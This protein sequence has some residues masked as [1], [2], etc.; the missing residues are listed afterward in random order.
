MTISI[1]KSR[2]GQIVSRNV[3][4]VAPETALQEAITLMASSR[5]SCLVVAE[6]KRPIGIFTERDLVKAIARHTELGS[7]PIRELMTCPVVTIHGKLNLYEAYSIMLSNK[8]RHHVVVDTVG[9]IMGVMS[10]SDLINVLGL[11]YFVEMRLIEQIMTKNV[12]TIPLQLKLSEALTRMAGA[13]ISCVV[14]VDGDCPVG[15]LTERDAVRLVAEGIDPESTLTGQVMSRPVLTVPFGTTLHKAALLMKQ[16]RIRH[17]VVV[18][19]KG[20]INGIVTQT[21]IVKGLEGKYIEALKEIIREKEDIFRQTAQEL[22]DKTF[23]LDNILNSSIDMAIVATDSDFNIKYFNPVA[24]NVF[25]RSP[26]NAI[27]RSALEL[28]DLRGAAGS[29]LERSLKIVRRRG[30]HDFA[31]EITHKGQTRYYQG[32]LSSILDRQKKLV[33]FVLMLQDV[34]ERRQQERIIHHMAYHDALTGLPNRVLLNDRLDQALTTVKRNSAAGALMILDLDRFKDINDSLGHSTGDA[35]L[36]EV[37]RRLAG[38]LRKSDTVSRMGGDE[39]VLLLPTIANSSSSE[40]IAGKIVRAFRKPFFCD[41]H[42]LKVTTSIGIANFPEDGDDA[43]TVLKNADI[44][45]YRVKETGRNSFQR[46]TPPE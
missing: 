41:G 6:K 12:M 30:K 13:G 39:F 14:V 23:Y 43:E 40:L 32:S 7:R 2:I 29:Y 34:S 33:G 26:A 11:E 9:R 19:D 1:H 4:T 42:T 25:N 18:D 31:T 20:A 5:I 27:G 46:Y 17:I 16:E 44:A 37:G 15:I 24:E 35:L 45:L 21:D 8:I 38:I 28:N 10:Q 36:K 3:V 22:L